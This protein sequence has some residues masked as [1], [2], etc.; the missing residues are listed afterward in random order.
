MLHQ[1]I[2]KAN[3]KAEEV[4]QII[5]DKMSE[6]LP[7]LI[8][9]AYPEHDGKPNDY[10][11]ADMMALRQTL[12]SLSTACQIWVKQLSEVIDIEEEKEQETKE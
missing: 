3:N 7:S 6:G 8:D 1:D 5:N 4:Y 12:N 9:I 10:V 2:I 11:I